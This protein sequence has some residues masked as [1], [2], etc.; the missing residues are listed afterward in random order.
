M[1]SP[2]STEEVWLSIKLTNGMLLGIVEKRRK[3]ANTAFETTLRPLERGGTWT[4]R[5]R[6]FWQNCPRR[7]FVQMNE[8]GAS[9]PNC[10]RLDLL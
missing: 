10:R 5:W 2:N 4:T 1:L 8:I 9:A 6:L 7:H 3:D